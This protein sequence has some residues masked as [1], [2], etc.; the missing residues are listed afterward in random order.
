MSM[1]KI[2]AFAAAAAIA[3]PAAAQQKHEMKV[4]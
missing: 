1:R 3:C 4:A 2:L